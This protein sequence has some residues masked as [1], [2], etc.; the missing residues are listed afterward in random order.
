MDAMPPPLD[1]SEL[2]AVAA[3]AE[4]D[5]LMEELVAA[6]IELA[7][8]EGDRVR[9]ARASLRARELRDGALRAVDGVRAALLLQEH[10]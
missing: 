7:E 4:R 2:E 1:D 8:A 3:A 5:Q 6:K 10:A 9:A